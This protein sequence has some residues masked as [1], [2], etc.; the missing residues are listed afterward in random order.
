MTKQI[1]TGNPKSASSKNQTKSFSMQIPEESYAYLF[2][3]ISH[4]I[5]SDVRYN[6]KRIFKDGLRFLKKKHP[7][8]TCGEGAER[9]FY[10]KIKKGKRPP[11]I[12]TSLL[13]QQKD[14]N[15]INN[16][17][18]EK[19]KKDVTYSKVNFVLDLVA[20]IRKNREKL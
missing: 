13:I 5:Q 4:K 17:I 18:D 12:A 7:R 8:I 9:R 14:I 3:E 16:Y 2:S 10:R 15:W 11:L 20:E 1:K 19:I 6:F